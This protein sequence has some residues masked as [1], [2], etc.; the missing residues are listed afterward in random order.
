MS[1]LRRIIILF[2]TGL[3]AFFAVAFV[4]V[5]WMRPQKLN[6]LTIGSIGEPQ[7]LN[8]IMAT[9]TAD[10][11]IHGLIFNGLVR[12]NEDIE[13]VPD[14][15]E[16]WEITQTST[17][18]F[19][20]PEQAGQAAAALEQHRAQWAEWNLT[21][22]Q[23]DGARL[24]LKFSSAGT[25]YQESLLAVVE[26]YRPMPV[27]FV[28]VSLNRDAKLEDE[29]AR[30]EPVLRRLTAEINAEPAL[31]ARLHSHFVN[32]SLEFDLVVAGDADEFVRLVNRVLRADDPA[33]AGQAAGRAE[34]AET[35]PVLN[36]PEILFVL[37][38]G[39]RWHNGSP[40][41]ARDVEFTYRSL[42]DERVASPRRA[43][44]E[45]VRSLY[46]LD[47]HTV[48]VV[49]RQPYA[50]CLL[51]WMM[52][53]LPHQVLEGK[54]S[55]WWAA[56][57]NRQPIGTG[58]YKFDEWRFGQYVRVRRS[59]DYWQGRPHLDFVTMRVI[60]DPVSV[61]LLFETGE[62]DFWGV[63]PHANQ[64]FLEDPR[65]EVFSRLAPGYNYIGWNLKR[66]LFQ[67]VRVRRALA[68]AV[69]VPQMV[70]YIV[71]GQGVQSTGPFPP[72]M[73]FANPQVQAYEYDPD[74]ARALLAEA[75]WQ[76]GPDGILQ[77]DGQRFEFNLITNHANEIRKDIATLVQSD[78]RGIGIR[79]RVQL[80]E[81]AVFISQ[82]IDKQDFDACVLGWSLGYDYDQYQ[83]WHSSQ[84]EPG[85]LNF[86]SYK[87][88]RVDRLLE[89]ARSEFDP[90]KAK[91]YTHELHR[92]IYE[93]QPYLFLYVPQSTAAMRR[94]EFRVKRPAEDEAWI[95]EPVRSTPIGFRIYQD[96]WYRPELMP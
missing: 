89:L 91:R 43:D 84:A 41:T 77:K 44:Y 2:P 26:T 83:L 72:N 47:E 56:N 54:D 11:E 27:G 65:Y 52:G 60:P 37:R 85:R 73:W 67:D 80:Y 57:F 69:N 70:E 16:R 35:F 79:V 10:S 95:D 15:A 94:G 40:F 29:P 13:V 39:V 46:V 14:L 93:D 9:T 87:N 12:Y 23:P 92:I 88:P 71:Y 5:W 17:L 62:I 22:T 19:A 78:L 31:A 25:A 42:M 53:I 30:S 18:F 8:P 21:G 86:C 36:E 50:P 63:E 75:G 66:P 33:A 34:V 68:H 1:W 32:T 58:A 96:W 74:R 3:L 55:Q 38:R 90:D 45:L 61:R 48:R 81:W 28:R 20:S 64:R 76:P 4:S 24:L 6:Q 82:Y 49:Y 51:S 59:E 7:N